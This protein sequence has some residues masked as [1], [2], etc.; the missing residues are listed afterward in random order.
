MKTKY[1]IL[2]IIMLIAISVSCTKSFEDFNTDVKN[3]S[4]VTGEALFTKAQLSL[5]DQVTSTDVNLNVF[6]LWAQYWTETTY[7]D[8]AN[9]NL[10][11][12][13]IADNTFQMYFI[14]NVS[15]EGGFLTDF[16]EATRIITEAVPPT[17]QAEAE[18]QNKL[19]I[20]ELL[21]VYAY[22][23]LVDIFG[24]I[25]YTEALDINNISPVYDDAATI[26]NDLI[27]RT[28]A[29]LGQLDPAFGSFGSAD[30]IYN[31]D[32]A[33][34]ILFANSL[35]LKIGTNLSDVNPTLARSTIESAIT[36]GVFTSFDDDAL[37]QYLGAIHTNPI[38]DDLVQS[39]RD[40]F[41]PANTVVNLMNSLTDPR[42]NE[43][44]TTLNG[45]YVGG[46]YGGN[47]P[48]TDYSHVAPAI[49]EP[50][51]PGVLLTYYE[52]LFYRAEAA[53]RGWSVGDTP[54]NLYNM[55]ITE[56][57]LWWGG[58]EAEA[59]AYLAQPNVAYSSATGLWQQKIGTQEYLAFYARGLEGF[60]TWRRLDYP[61]LN[62]APSISRYEQIPKRYTYPIN[63]Q[64]LNNA[65]Y[66]SAS[67]AIGGDLLTTRIFW[68]VR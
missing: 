12:R 38:F 48:F 9:Y 37:L 10:V 45:Q 59:A 14:G 52:V 5:V 55:A 49:T 18:N 54:A 4:K 34:W 33:K 39:G 2:Y 63:E 40:D 21:T 60:T 1:Y 41:I 13:T 58:S 46:I 22:H 56:S 67:Q 27:A 68:D 43:Y 36:G 35:K 50:T 15:K 66:T 11:D 16:K 26:Y 65:S 20:I 44:F 31:G 57:I 30:L 3:P 8:E 28:D 23:N 47:N 7:T 64:T 25:P 61:I 51:F 19:A 6:K 24:N 62:L 53:A 42:R 17:D 29:A 32:V